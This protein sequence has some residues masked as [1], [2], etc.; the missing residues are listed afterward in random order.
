M[1][2]W[3][4]STFLKGLLFIVPGTATIFITIWAFRLIDGLLN[5]HV[6]GLGFLICIGITFVV[7]ALATSIIFNKT[8]DALERGLTRLPLVKLIYFS[9]KDLIGAFVGEKKRFQI[10]VLVDMFGTHPAVKMVGF[11]TQENVP[12]IDLPDHVAVYLPQAYNFSGVTVVVPRERILRLKE[13]DAAKWMAFIVSGGVSQ[14][15]NAPGE[16]RQ[17]TSIP[18]PNQI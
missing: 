11:L 13:A 2:K 7:G 8:V 3:L 16:D 14:G 4:L 10:P 17:T 1:M 9:I 15:V 18:I 6:P 5:L 12:M